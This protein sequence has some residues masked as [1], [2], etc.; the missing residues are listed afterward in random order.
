MF[1]TL[2]LMFFFSSRRRHTRCALVT[3]VQTCALPI[4]KPD[5]EDR[6]RQPRELGVDRHRAAAGMPAALRLAARDGKPRF[7]QPPARA[8]AR[9]HRRRPQRPIAPIAR[10]L[11][12]AR[13]AIGGYLRP[14]LYR[15]WTP[16]RT[17]ERRAPPAPAP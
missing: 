4:L 11:G 6:Q 9:H 17:R 15:D 8:L 16:P 14:R 13:V 2:L 3:G 1:V 10:P 5:I 12:A 7:G